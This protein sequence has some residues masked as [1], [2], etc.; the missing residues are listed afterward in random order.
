MQTSEEI[1]FMTLKFYMVID[2]YKYAFFVDM[3]S[4]YSENVISFIL[5]LHLGFCFIITNKPSKLGKE[6]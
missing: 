5:S 1:K 6:I 2:F 3:T 4:L